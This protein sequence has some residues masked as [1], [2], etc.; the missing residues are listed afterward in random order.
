M[1]E[2]NSNKTKIW[3]RNDDVSSYDDNYRKIIE[4]YKKYGVPTII[5][6]IPTI[7]EANCLYEIKDC[8]NFVLSQHG[9]S[10]KNYK[11]IFSLAYSIELCDKRDRK[12]VIKEMLY[13]KEKLEKLSKMPVDILTPPYNRIDKNL[14]LELSSYYKILSTY[15]NNTSSFEKDL[16]PCID[17]INWNTGSFDKEHFIKKLK[18]KIGKLDEVGI[19]IHHNFLTY[20]DILFLDEI[21]SNLESNNNV[22]LRRVK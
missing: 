15:G 18:E 10:H 1:K 16:N 14:E 2:H 17:I 3:I 12:E 6:A 22:V 21:F 11:N 13:G 5:C 19:C 8:D 4:L 20:E 9:Y 7:I